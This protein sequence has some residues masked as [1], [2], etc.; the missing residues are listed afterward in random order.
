MVSKIYFPKAF[1]LY[2]ICAVG[3]L[4]PT[5]VHAENCAVVEVDNMLALNTA[6]ASEGVYS[7]KR[8]KSNK[9]QTKRTSGMPRLHKATGPSKLP[10]N[11]AGCP[12]V[13]IKGKDYPSMA[14][15]KSISSNIYG[16][17]YTFSIGADHPNGTRA[18]VS[19]DHYGYSLFEDIE[20]S[21]GEYEKFFDEFGFLKDECNMQITIMDF[22]ND[23]ECELLFSLQSE[24]WVTMTTYVFKLLPNP[25]KFSIV[26][27]IGA[28]DGQCYMFIDN[29]NIIAPFGSQGLF[30]EYM[31]TPDG[32]LVGINCL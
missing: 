24:D 31:L 1:V 26:K 4:L 7:N 10:F 5:P 25:D 18:M 15:N 20:F 21:D 27:Y 8:T 11:P 22:N 30:E 17:N 29:N 9:R 14:K 12:Y 2:V 6:S 28:A 19:Y 23:G 13:F 3:V 16:R 32:R